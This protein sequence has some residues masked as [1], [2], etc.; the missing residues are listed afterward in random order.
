MIRENNN[1]SII[2]WLEEIWEEIEVQFLGLIGA[3]IFFVM[4]YLFF[5]PPW[6]RPL[7]ENF[8]NIKF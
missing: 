6:M 3:I 1:K 5:Q 2:T 8:F 7:I 4:L